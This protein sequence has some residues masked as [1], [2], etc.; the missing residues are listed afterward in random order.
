MSK[1]R[2][3]R[4]R[5]ETIRLSPYVASGDGAEV[6]SVSARLRK[7]AAGQRIPQPND[8][9]GTPFTVASRLASDDL[10]AGWE[11][12]IDA[13]TSATLAPGIY[14]V[15]LKLILTSGETV[16]TDPATVEL[17]EPATP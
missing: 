9:P 6:A 7:L 2:Y 8:P 12:T 15:D 3:I 11:I 1:T 17:K 14:T 4:Q 13:A 10:P 5:G 16:I